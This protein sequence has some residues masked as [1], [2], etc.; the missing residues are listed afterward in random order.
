MPKPG[1]IGLL[2]LS[3]I[4]FS[5]IPLYF[6]CNRPNYTFIPSLISYD[7][8]PILFS[9]FLGITH[10]H[11]NSIIFGIP[12]DFNTPEKQSDCSKLFVLILGLGLSFGAL[13]SIAINLGHVQTN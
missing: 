2:L 8:I 9:A 1:S 6:I 11:L 10:G 5:F 13:V 12:Y 7:F 4:R 3:V